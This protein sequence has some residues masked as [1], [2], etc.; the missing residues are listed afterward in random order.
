MEKREALQIEKQSQIFY[1]AVVER[2]GYADKVLTEDSLERLQSAVNVW[3][4]CGEWS[5]KSAEKVD[6]VMTKLIA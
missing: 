5:L 6:R 4:R 1:E 2:Q 3:T